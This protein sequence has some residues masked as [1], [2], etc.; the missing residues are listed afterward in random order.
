MND[1]VFGELTAVMR[2]KKSREDMVDMFR[3]SITISVID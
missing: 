3:L 2:R 1:L